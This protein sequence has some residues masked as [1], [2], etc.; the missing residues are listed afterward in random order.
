MII[1]I[2]VRII[3]ALIYPSIILTN[4]FVDLSNVFQQLECSKPKFTLTQML[5]S[6]GLKKHLTT[7]TD[8]SSKPVIG[9]EL[10]AKGKRTNIL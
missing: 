5:G 2:E 8:R 7:V 10:K 9:S 6:G 3:R 4:L 1:K